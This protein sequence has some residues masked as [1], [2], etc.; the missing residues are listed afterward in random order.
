VDRRV[1]RDTVSMGHSRDD[2]PPIRGARNY[3]FTVVIIFMG[4]LAK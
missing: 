3:I 1:G 4:F 2:C